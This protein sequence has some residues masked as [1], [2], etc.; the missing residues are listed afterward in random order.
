MLMPCDIISIQSKSR[1]E[2]VEEFI[3]ESQKCLVQKATTF[4]SQ[5][6]FMIAKENFDSQEKL[7]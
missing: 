6:D 4:H 1:V 7:F 2:L 5:L 3:M